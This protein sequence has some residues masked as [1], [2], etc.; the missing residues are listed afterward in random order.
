MQGIDFCEEDIF[1]ASSPQTEDE[2]P[3]G[4]LAPAL[5]LFDLWEIHQQTGAEP[6]EEIYIPNIFLLGP[7]P[8]SF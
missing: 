8:F 5:I 1:F 7:N 2:K 6:W 4:F 3:A